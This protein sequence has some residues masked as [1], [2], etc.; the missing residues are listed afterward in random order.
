MH[1][2]QNKMLAK[3]R[4]GEVVLGPFV[5][6][7]D[8]GVVELL[9]YVGFD[10]VLLDMEHSSMDLQNVENMIRAAEVSGTTPVVRVPD[11]NHKFILRV[12]EAGAQG[13]VVP[14]VFT[15]VEAMEIVKHM[16]YAPQGRRGIGRQR[17]AMYGIADAAEYYAW[18]NRE[19]MV[20]IMV[21]DREAV[22]NIDEIAQVDGVD[23]IFVGPGDLSATL[24]VPGGYQLP[25]PQEYIDRAITAIRKAKKAAIG[26]PGY[27]ESEVPTLVSKGVRFI[28]SPS[29]DKGMLSACAAEALARIR[30]SIA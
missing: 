27:L 24:G 19:I 22:E 23:L 11:N 3:L 30:R 10:F 8:P 7:M 14:H 29:S 16:K 25:E 15:A 4:N 5:Y 17:A 18:A 28:T 9:G 2:K 20:G 12:L 6:F 1:V 13:I 26:M 21:E